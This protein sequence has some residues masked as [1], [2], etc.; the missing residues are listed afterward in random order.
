MKPW[1]QGYEVELGEPL[2]NFPQGDDIIDTTIMNEVVAQMIRQSPEQYFWVHKRF[3]TRP[4]GDTKFY[5]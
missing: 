3:K 5:N 2:A 1:G 4:E